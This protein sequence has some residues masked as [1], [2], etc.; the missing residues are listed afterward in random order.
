MR[1]FNIEQLKA[2]VG[3]E[4]QFNLFHVNVLPNQCFR[5]FQKESF[6]QFGFGKYEQG[7]KDYDEE[8]AGKGTND[9]ENTTNESFFSQRQKEENNSGI[10]ARISGPPR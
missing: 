8:E 10:I 5:L 4:C 3:K 9:E 6:R 1:D 7:G 2:R